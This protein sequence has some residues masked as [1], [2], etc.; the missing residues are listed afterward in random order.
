M[1][2]VARLITRRATVGMSKASAKWAYGVELWY[3]F[4][5]AGVYV[6]TCTIKRFP[7][8]GMILFAGLAVH[9][10][11]ATWRGVPPLPDFAAKHKE[12]VTADAADMVADGHKHVLIGSPCDYLYCVYAPTRL[13][14]A[15]GLRPWVRPMAEQVEQSI[16]PAVMDALPAEVLGAD[17]WQTTHYRRAAIHHGFVP[18][19]AGRL[20]PH[21]QWSIRRDVSF[22]AADRGVQDGDLSLLRDD[23]F[24]TAWEDDT[25]TPVSLTVDFDRPRKVCRLC[26]Y[27]HRPWRRWHEAVCPGPLEI[28][29]MQRDGQWVTL[30]T[31]ALESAYSWA[32]C[33]PFYC[34]YRRRFD[35][36]L[37]ISEILRLR[38]RETHREGRIRRRR[39]HELYVFEQSGHD[40]TTSPTELDAVAEFVRSRGAVAFL[41]D[42]FISAQVKKRCA[43]VRTWMQSQHD[44]SSPRVKRDHWPWSTDFEAIPALGQRERSGRGQPAPAVYPRVATVLAIENAFAA[45]ADRLLA[46]EGLQTERRTIGA[47]TLHALPEQDD[48][49]VHDLV[50]SGT[51]LGYLPSK[52]SAHVWLQ[53]RAASGPKLGREQTVARLRRIVTAFPR[54]REA[55]AALRDLEPTMSLPSNWLEYRVPR[56]TFAAPVRFAGGVS[57]VA[58]EI[59]PRT[60]RAG[61]TVSVCYAWRIPNHWARA[62]RGRPMVFSHFVSPG[63]TIN[64]DHLLLANYPHTSLME[65]LPD[66]VFIEPR[67]VRIPADAPTGGYEIEIGLHLQNE[68]FNV[69]TDAPGI[70]IHRR[71]ALVPGF[72]VTVRTDSTSP[73]VDI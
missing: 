41:G 59:T 44:P 72:E 31:N 32:G 15:H 70:R 71:A 63:L 64:D 4:T 38:L 67:S 28:S 7:K 10:G 29:G 66:E 60:P 19:P 20:I 23:T 8:L 16:A 6:L 1:P 40:E 34:A 11:I 9:F 61:D 24:T 26:L 58:V 53:T 73:H 48:A 5:L 62:R 39:V 50:W 65:C 46:N 68:R 51:C 57:L 27:L 18:P 36:R 21:D 2:T 17:A 56:R 69:E 45:A 49:P 54:C 37:P 33:R 43:S 47:Y 35:I 12:V 22:A 42:R 14:M 25:E 30:A 3:W 13:D 55:W 52:A